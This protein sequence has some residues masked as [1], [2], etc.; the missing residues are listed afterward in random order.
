MKIKNTLIK[1]SL[2]CLSL[3]AV[4][5][6]NSDFTDTT[7]TTSV[8]EGL[9]FS[10]GENLLTAIN[11]IHRRVNTG[12]YYGQ[13]TWGMS[14]QMLMTEA[15]ADDV[16]YPSQGNGWYIS[17]SR[18]NSVVS[19]TSDQVYF[20]WELWYQAIK[21]ANNIIMFGVNA[22]G[23][24]VKKEQA[25]GEAYAYRAFGMFQMV[26]VYGGRYVK[27]ID[28]VQ[29][30]VVI[31]LDPS[32]QTAKARSSVEDV[33]K[34]IWLDLAEAEK[35]LKGKTKINPSH[36]NYNT[37]K[38]IQ[39]RVALTQGDWAKAS[40]AASEAKSGYA[41]MT[42]AQ[43]KSGF[44]SATNSEWI[45]GTQSI[46]DQSEAF[47]MFHS[48]MA[49]NALSTNVRQAPK[50]MNK[51][52]HSSFPSTDVRAQVVDP[53]GVHAGFV[54]PRTGYAKFPYTSVKFLLANPTIG[55]AAD[56]PYMRSAEMY[57]VEAE[58]LARQGKDA[59]ARTVFALLEK[60]RNPS[61]VTTTSSGDKLLQE[62]L[63]S[64]RIELWGEGFRWYDLKRM[65][66][67]LDRTLAGNFVT[68]VINNVYKIEAN[69]NRWN[70]L[71]PRQEINSN[72]EVKQN[73]LN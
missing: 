62:I 70:W 52:L 30:G 55:V 48:Y 66:L 53:T 71:I 64:R 38:G 36:F 18:W 32:D 42:N 9:V 20:F 59:E 67:P 15:M 19:E 50:A 7:P 25:L 54:F 47:A 14:G 21:N 6:C 35:Y 60:N 40:A 51:A 45:W 41:L 58:A 37:V 16:V 12:R 33:Y 39:A 61:Y 22:G 28:N 8:E 10:T 29:P 65:N 73:P 56:T 43:Y 46:E 24:Q 57:L 34:Q 17:D 5:S 44:N 72:P 4:Q 69:D 27:G 23:D 11:G 13:G 3:L 68:S 2:A 63:L 49:R 26:Q 31:R 1:T